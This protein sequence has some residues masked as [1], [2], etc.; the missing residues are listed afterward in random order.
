MPPGSV[1]L[2]HPGSL[3]SLGS[4]STAAPEIAAFPLLCSAADV[5]MAGYFRPHSR[6][7]LPPV[8]VSKRRSSPRLYREMPKQKTK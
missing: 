5:S 6:C 4:R 2:G 8:P 1:V 7:S 3:P